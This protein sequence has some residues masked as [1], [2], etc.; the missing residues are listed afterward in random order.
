MGTNNTSPYLASL[1][2]SHIIVLKIHCK[3]SCENLEPLTWS[4][5]YYTSN[6][7]LLS[8]LASF[9][10]EETAFIPWQKA[11]GK[12]KCEVVGF[13]RLMSSWVLYGI[14]VVAANMWAWHVI[15]RFPA[16]YIITITLPTKDF[17][18]FVC[19]RVWGC[20]QKLSHLTAVMKCQVLIAVS[21][22]TVG[23]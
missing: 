1:F 23:Q 17:S 8:H 16:M 18:T 15:L 20:M 13:H 9:V 11:G 7:A 4:C 21:T 6:A 2:E 3:T 14:Q 10:E 19:N 5:M 22:W 12:C